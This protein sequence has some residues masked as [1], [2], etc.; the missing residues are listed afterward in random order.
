MPGFKDG[1][2]NQAE[3]SAPSSILL[4][5]DHKTLYVSDSG[6]NALR[7]V[8]LDDACRV[9]TLCGVSG[10]GQVDGAPDVARLKRPGR[11]RLSADGRTLYFLDQAGLALRSMD[12]LSGTVRT[13]LDLVTPTASQGSPSFDLDTAQKGI[14][15]TVPARNALL[16]S[17]LDGKVTRTVGTDPLY[18]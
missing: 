5:Q 2:S 15:F 8:H 18:G 7:A 16:Y 9:T 4:S 12:L 3:F 1:N 13:V 14:Y 17:S 10:S 11:L 6:N